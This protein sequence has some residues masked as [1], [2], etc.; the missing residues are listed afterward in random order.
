M[1]YKFCTLI[2]IIFNR[3]PCLL[4]KHFVLSLYTTHLRSVHKPPFIRKLKHAS[5]SVF[6]RHQYAIFISRV[7]INIVSHYRG[8]IW[9]KKCSS[10]VILIYLRKYKNTQNFRIL[11]IVY[12]MVQ[13]FLK[14]TRK[15]RG[16]CVI[17]TF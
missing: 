2:H 9:H 14:L 4:R 12:E 7:W 16:F 15:A 10:D 5:A 3:D 8:T 1:Q 11:A 6:K 17:S 13:S